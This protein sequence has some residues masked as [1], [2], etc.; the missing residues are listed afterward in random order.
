M[1]RFEIP[2][3]Q[4][5]HLNRGYFHKAYNEL[6]MQVGECYAAFSNNSL[7]E[8][9]LIQKR[10][11]NKLLEEPYFDAKA[12]KLIDGGFRIDD[13]NISLFWFS[14]FSAVLQVD[15]KRFDALEKA[16]SF[17]K[18]QADTYQKEFLQL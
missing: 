1:K 10:V 5:L 18:V 6:D 17:V 4:R 15:R 3:N 7:Q 13:V 8:M 12:I 14:Q 16:I 11:Y 2:S 9:W